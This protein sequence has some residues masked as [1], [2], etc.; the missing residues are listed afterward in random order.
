MKRSHA[1]AHLITGI[2]VVAA[3]AVVVAA[4]VAV[5]RW[6]GTSTAPKAAAGGSPAASAVAAG[7]LTAAGS[8]SPAPAA[9]RGAAGAWSVSA[10]T[11]LPPTH[12]PYT[13]ASDATVGTSSGGTDAGAGSVTAGAPAAGATSPASLAPPA[14]SQAPPKPAIISQLIPFGARRRA[15]TVAYN[16]RHYGQATW[17]LTPKAIVLHYTAGGTEAGTHAT[18]AADTPN[19]GVLPGVVAHFVI[20]RNGRIY[21]QLSLGIRGRHAVGLNHVAIGIEFVQDAGSG[22]TWA[23]NQIFA[24]RPQIAAGLRL[25]RWL[26]WRYNIATSNVIGHAMANHSPLF[27][28]LLGW[29][30]THTDWNTAAVRRFHNLLATG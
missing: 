2:A 3:C 17:R 16:R 5:T 28:D 15:E 8:A 25:V 20:D 13:S 18:F 24:R 23:T 12:A 21:Q 30:N 26:Q 14:A 4:A 7:N 19:M 1:G 11:R 27:K 6:P 10:P 9:S 29:R 22:S